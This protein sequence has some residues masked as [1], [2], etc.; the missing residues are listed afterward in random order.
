MN[1][2]ASKVW[3]LNYQ[4]VKTDGQ[5]RREGSGR[6]GDGQERGCGEQE[7]VKEKKSAKGE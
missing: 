1:V 3:L 7:R 4:A 5:R 6:V 2:K